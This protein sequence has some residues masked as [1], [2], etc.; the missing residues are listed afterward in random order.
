MKLVKVGFLAAIIS[1]TLV[2][3]GCENHIH[4]EYWKPEY[5]SYMA[6]YGYTISEDRLVISKNGVPV[7][8]NYESCGYRCTRSSVYYGA[9]G[10]YDE[11]VQDELNAL[12]KAIEDR[13][14]DYRKLMGL[15]K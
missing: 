4:E 8:K 7:F 12:K 3:S 15:P 1:T 10:L 6:K 2:L 14:A 5:D 13:N 9:P 11:M